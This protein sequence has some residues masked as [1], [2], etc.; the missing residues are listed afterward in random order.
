MLPF[1]L[2]TRGVTTRAET[3]ALW[4]ESSSRLAA[5][6]EREIGSA[7]DAEDL[8]QETFVRVHARIDTLVDA[9]SVRAWVG[10]IARNVLADYHRRRGAQAETSVAEEAMAP[11]R[12]NLIEQE[13]AAWLESFIAQLEPGDADA[14]RFVDLGGHTQGELAERDGISLPGAKSRVQRARAKLRERLEHCCAFAF[15]SRGGL[16]SFEKRPHGDCQQGRCG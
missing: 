4:R 16:L 8:L 14:L 5:W 3:E 13:V 10:T 2:G 1:G 11:D 7:A 9:S 12:Q 15:D 6:F